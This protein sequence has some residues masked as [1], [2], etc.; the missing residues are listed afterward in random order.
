MAS[1]WKGKTSMWYRA[2]WFT[3]EPLCRG[4]WKELQNDLK[5]FNLNM[6]TVSLIYRGKWCVVSLN[7]DGTT[8]SQAIQQTVTKYIQ[9]GT[10]IEIDQGALNTLLARHLERR[11]HANYKPSGPGLL[12]EG[13]DPVSMPYLAPESEEEQREQREAVIR[14]FQERG[15]PFLEIY[16]LY[17][18][19]QIESDF[20]NESMIHPYALKMGELALQQLRNAERY[21]F[22]DSARAM[23]RAVTKGERTWTPPV[24]DTWIEQDV[25]QALFPDL[26][27]KLKAVYLKEMF[28]QSLYTSQPEPFRSSVIESTAVFRGTW[29]VG[30]IDEHAYFHLTLMYDSLENDFH[31]SFDH[32]CPYA[33]C[34]KLTFAEIVTKYSMD[35]LLGV[36]VP[37]YYKEMQDIQPEASDFPLV[38]PCENCKR[39]A[40]LLTAWLHTA[41]RQV[42][43]DY[44]LSSTPAPFPVKNL[45][46]TEK[47]LV[48]RHHGKGK[49]KEKQVPVY[50]PYTFITYDVSIAP[51]LAST[52]GRS[53]Q[54]ERPE[55]PTR[56]SWFSLHGREDM[57]FEKRE[58][59]DIKRHYR[60]PYFKALVE[61]VKQGER[62][63]PEGEEYELLQEADNYMVVGTVRF[64][65]GR[66][67]P[68][69]KPEA[70]KQVV[71]KR[72][73]ASK[74]TEKPEK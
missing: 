58:Q 54:G 28:P 24:R 60:L 21:M 3:S 4:T 14:T 29:S 23:H 40:L 20:Y 73:I 19:G 65:H 53:D 17:Y 72:V 33:K 46:Y 52:S 66:Y 59:A 45:S 31:I 43:G 39:N 35:K 25:P 42:R 15:Y 63:S 8:P 32:A 47:K 51:A 34:E 49:P 44:A 27:S 57:I 41:M 6:F 9:R 12:Y 61:K 71:Y 38:L 68:M 50:L 11:Q 13:H 22:T 70:K 16:A 1:A 74:Y 64:P 26:P 67:V 48:E 56:S 10:P 2:S 69:L 62:H 36:R 18:K 7:T 30:V 37:R 55:A 5:R